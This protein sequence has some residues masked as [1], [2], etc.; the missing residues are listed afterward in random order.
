[1]YVI[2][3]EEHVVGPM[4]SNIEI[5]AILKD[6][7][8][9]EAIATRISDAGPETIHQEDFF[10]VSRGARLKL[11]MLA[12]DRGELIRYERA[13]VSDARRS[14]YLIAR[15]PDPGM[16][17]EILTATLGRTGVVR[18]TRVLYLVG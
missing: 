11:R 15:T 18:K 12:P 2:L 9:A 14:R 13:D 17:L 1:M 16:L 3:S 5:K 6:R 8:A 4:P 7:I 10:F